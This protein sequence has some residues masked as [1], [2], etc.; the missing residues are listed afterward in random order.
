MNGIV[1]LLK[2]PCLSSAQAVSFMKRLTGQKA[3]HAGTLDPDACGVLPIMVGKAT[4]LFDYLVEKEKTYVTEVSFGVSTDTQDA[5]GRVISTGDNVPTAERVK[6]ILPH[7]IGR[8]WQVPP[9]FSAIKRDGRALYES[10]RSGGFTP[11]QAR[12]IDVF[13]IEY[14]HDV[15]PY[16]HLLRITCGKGTYIRT[17]CHDIGQALG[18]PAHMRMLIREQSGPFRIEEAITMEALSAFADHGNADGPWLLP[19]HKALAHLPQVTFKPSSWKR[20][21]NGVGMGYDEI[22]PAAQLEV[23]TVAAGWCD[24]RLVGIYAVERE[25]LRVRTLL[26]EKDAD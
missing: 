26:Y 7:F 2:P 13:S 14:L 1:N 20:C 11:V 24:G 23:G 18:C 22:H 16:G 5:S 3:G 19:V 6:A 4:R 10:A 9:Q 12:P 25:G 21:I 17:I 8:V 15:P